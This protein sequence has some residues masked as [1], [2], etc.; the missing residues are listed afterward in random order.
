MR[1]IGSTTTGSVI[2]EMTA[3]QF[4]ALTQVIT[5]DPQPE[6]KKPAS[7]PVM[8]LKR[9]QTNVRNCLDQLRPESRQEVIRSIRAM[10]RGMG[11]IREEEIIQIME[12]LVKEG[13]FSFDADERACYSDNAKP[14]SILQKQNS[15]EEKGDTDAQQDSVAPAYQGSL[16]KTFTPSLLVEVPEGDQPV[17]GNGKVR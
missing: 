4:A 10:Y 7:L 12:S 17:D 11:G 1:K 2:I 5:A 15:R 3:A 16:E 6:E 8:A 14:V 9:K 13:Y